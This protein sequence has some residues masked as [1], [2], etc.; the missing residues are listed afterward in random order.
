[1]LKHY[2]NVQ[3]LKITILTSHPHPQ[4][5]TTSQRV[6]PF[7]PFRLFKN[8]FPPSD[9]I[10]KNNVFFHPQGCT[11]TVPGKNLT[12]FT[13]LRSCENLEEFVGLCL[14][15]RSCARY[16]KPKAFLHCCNKASLAPISHP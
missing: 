8:T 11:H 10:I 3:I 4:D 13:Y 14:F 1:M 15:P 16:T 6:C 9:E 12:P 7:F 2:G 5:P